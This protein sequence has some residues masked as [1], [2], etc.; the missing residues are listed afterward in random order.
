MP[1]Q[2]KGMNRCARLCWK[3][4]KESLCNTASLM[5]ILKPYTASSAI[6]GYVRV[7]AT[8]LC[9]NLLQH[10]DAPVIS[11]ASNEHAEYHEI[12]L[13]VFLLYMSLKCGRHRGFLHFG[14]PNSLTRRAGNDCCSWC[15]IGLHVLPD[16]WAWGKKQLLCCVFIEHL[17]SRQAY[18]T[19]SLSKDGLHAFPS[20]MSGVYVREQTCLP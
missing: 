12:L 13:R 3:Y 7:A 16:L 19:R 9:A 1:R 20:Y 18:H 10:V 4:G 14:G 11:L 17:S 15:L 2:N 6:Q 8:T 5:P